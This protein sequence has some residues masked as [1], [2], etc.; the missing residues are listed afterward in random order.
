MITIIGG[1]GFVGSSLC[2]QLDAAGMPFEI[3]DLKLSPYFP[4]RTK[5]V[6]IRDRDALKVALTGNVV[7]NLAAVHRDDVENVENYY[8]TNVD[9]ARALCSVCEAKNVKQIIF[10]S[11]VAVYGAVTEPIGEDGRINPNNH[12]G[13]SKA[14]AEEVFADWH[15]SAPNVRSLYIVRPTV[16][17]GAGNRGNVFNLLNQ[18]N[19]GLFMMIGPGNNKKSMAY[20]ENVAAFLTACISAE[21]GHGVFNYVDHPDFSMNELIEAINISLKGKAGVGLRIPYSMGLFLGAIA[22]GLAIFGIRLPISTM[23]IKKFCASSQFLS[24]KEELAGFV[25][26]VFLRDGLQATLD[27][28]FKN[29]DEN[30]PIFFTE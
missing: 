6:D 30:R 27:A 5:I 9:G 3:L 11:S 15:N 17:F 8:S 13:K 24:A 2:R 12:Y 29:P 18:V 22:D 14:M 16:V 19:S 20:V 21:A 26:P 28:E 4:E 1:A 10:T 23:R 25:P 7:I